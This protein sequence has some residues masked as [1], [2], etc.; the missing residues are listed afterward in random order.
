M[1]PVCT[2]QLFG[3]GRVALPRQGAALLSAAAAGPF[4]AS[5]TKLEGFVCVQRGL[6]IGNERSEKEKDRGTV[7]NGPKLPQLT[8]AQPGHWCAKGVIHMCLKWRKC[9][10]K[11]KSARFS[12]KDHGFVHQAVLLIFLLR[13]FSWLQIC[14]QLTSEG[15]QH[16]GARGRATSS[17]SPGLSLAARKI[18]M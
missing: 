3:E 10:E 16:G 9:L 1:W 18:G 4:W 6:G 13:Q 7:F 17:W 5:H 12:V 2:R 14:S 8:S 15:W 11:R